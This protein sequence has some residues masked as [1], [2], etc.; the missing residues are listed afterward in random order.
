MSSFDRTP[1]VVYCPRCKLA[2]P[3]ESTY[4][5]YCGLLIAQ[6]LPGTSTQLLEPSFEPNTHTDRSLR[7][8]RSVVIYGTSMLLLVGVCALFVLHFTGISPL[9]L[10]S[11]RAP[12]PKDIVYAVP[13]GTPLFADSFSSDAYGWNLQSSQGK[14]TVTLGNG[15]LGLK[16]EK[17]NVLWELVPGERT[18]SNFTLTVELSSAREIRI[19]ATESIFEVPQ[20]KKPIWLPII[21]SNCTAMDHMRYL[22]VRA[23]RVATP[24]RQKW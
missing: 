2:L 9:S 1:I 23:L 11:Y 15:V 21:A 16:V 5:Y 22:R 24:L 14:Y 8:H 6:V 10:F 4:C 19:T 18:F 3:P 17:H 12:R 7:R 20:I 13:K